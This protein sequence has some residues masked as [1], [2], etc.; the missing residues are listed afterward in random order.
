MFY[1]FLINFCLIYS[2]DLSL[3]LFTPSGKYCG[4]IGG[5]KDNEES[6]TINIKA[7]VKSQDRI[8]LKIKIFGNDYNCLNEKVIIHQNNS[9]SFPNSYSRQNCIYQIF[10]T[11]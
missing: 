11:F 9:L 1:I 10:N 3:N 5:S 4:H 8:D 2:Y 6:G 7:L